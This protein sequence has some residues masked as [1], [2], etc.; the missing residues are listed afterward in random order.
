MFFPLYDIM[1]QALQG[2]HGLFGGAPQAF[3][4]VDG[5]DL[6]L[7]DYLHVSERDLLSAVC[8]QWSICGYTQNDPLPSFSS[9]GGNGGE[10]GSA[11]MVVWNLS[12]QVAEK[13]KK[14]FLSIPSNVTLTPTAAISPPLS[15]QPLCFLFL[16]LSF[17]CHLCSNARLE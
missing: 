8:L 6:H 7:C 1:V 16:S 17:F 14:R 10:E 15:L 11:V 13:K 5:A 3:S 9:T 4:D 2:L 12:L